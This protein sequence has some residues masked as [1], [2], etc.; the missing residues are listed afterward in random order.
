MPPCTWISELLLQIAINSLGQTQLDPPPPTHSP[1]AERD[2]GYAVATTQQCCHSCLSQSQCEGPHQQHLPCII[3]RLRWQVWLAASIVDEGGREG[4][5]S[6]GR[7]SKEG[8]VEVLALV[9]GEWVAT[10]GLK[11]RKR[12]G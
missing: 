11:S 1:A 5:R 2:G 12:D 9:M 3:K 8:S 6:R 10:A 4:G 7:R